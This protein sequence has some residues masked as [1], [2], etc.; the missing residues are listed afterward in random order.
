MPIRKPPDIERDPYKS[1]KWDEL[2]AGRPIG[3]AQAPALALLCQWYK[4]LDQAVAEMDE[5]AGGQTVYENKMGDVRAL[6]Q[7]ATIKTASAEIR[8][9]NKQLGIN[10]G[11]EAEVGDGQGGSIL[12]LVSG[13]KAD[14]RARAAV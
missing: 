2:S 3:A 8:A 6:P 5:M 9:L 4:I 14:R 11:A 1:A 13:R 10:D 12:T 7:I